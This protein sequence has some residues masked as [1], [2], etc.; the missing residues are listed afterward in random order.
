L[1]LTTPVPDQDAAPTAARLA[2]RIEIPLEL[3]VRYDGQRIRSLSKTSYE[4]FCL[5]PDAYRRRYICGE[6]E[7]TTG[8]MFLGSRLDDAMTH[9][10]RT[11]IDTGQTLPLDQVQR[12]YE[13][14][15][16]EQL[17]REQDERGVDWSDLHDRAAFE[18]GKDAIEV[19]INQFAPQLGDPVAVQRKFA[20]KV[21]SHAQWTVEGYPDLEVR[22]Y[23][24]GSDEPVAGVVD[25]KVKGKPVYQPKA[26][27]DV[28]A[29]LYLAARW[30]EG[31][32]ANDFTLAQVLRPGPERQKISSKIVRTTRTIEQ[33]R[34]TL[35]RF[36]QAASQIAWLHERFGSDRPWGFADP[37]HW[38]CTEAQCPYWSSCPGGGG[39][40]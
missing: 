34:A 33:L 35:A 15:W 40:Q 38:K 39:L 37:S 2:A 36:A 31:D 22:R 10:Y 27:C 16:L 28:Q 7:P 25:W 3:P 19:C 8:R 6:R 24:L 4:T 17:E 23:E 21:T 29:S 20:F 5:C 13:Q 9:Y 32:P 11:L 14:N 30:V 18:I 26:D 12:F 1:A